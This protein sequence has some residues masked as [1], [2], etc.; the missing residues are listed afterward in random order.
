MRPWGLLRS[1]LAQQ[2]GVADTDS[3]E[4]TTLSRIGQRVIPK[5]VRLSAQRVPGDVL[6]VRYGAGA[7]RLDP[8]VGVVA[9]ALAAID[10]VRDV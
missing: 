9:A 2:C 8:V 10:L 1:L 5:A 3:A 6:S 7:I 4:T